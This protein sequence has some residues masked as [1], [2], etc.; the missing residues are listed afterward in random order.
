MPKKTN[1]RRSSKAEK[2]KVS[3]K[4]VN[5]SHAQHGLEEAFSVLF[6]YTLET[7]KQKTHQRKT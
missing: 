2:I 3:Y 6:I 7:K 5:L 1:K 4:Q